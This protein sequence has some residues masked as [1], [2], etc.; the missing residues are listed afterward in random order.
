[1]LQRTVKTIITE[2]I[3]PTVLKSLAVSEL[4]PNSI[5]TGDKAGS[6]CL[7][8]S[9]EPMKTINAIEPQ[10][11]CTFVAILLALANS[12]LFIET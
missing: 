5:N 8:I 1:M 7:T 4:R 12:S 3:T 2:N 9:A 11:V 10:I 6:I